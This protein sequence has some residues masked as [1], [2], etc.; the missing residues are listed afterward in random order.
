MIAIVTRMLRQSWYT[1]AIRCR[2]VRHNC[3]RTLSITPPNS[4][5]IVWPRRPRPERRARPGLLQGR[6]LSVPPGARCPA[7]MHVSGPYGLADVIRLRSSTPI[8][9]RGSIH[10]VMSFRKAVNS[11][12]GYLSES[13]QILSG[14]SANLHASAVFRCRSTFYYCRSLV[15]VVHMSVCA[16]A[17]IETLDFEDGKYD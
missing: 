2:S 9:W 11:R 7:F 5:G 15:L 13:Y 8:C 1:R 6:R 16:S 17:R 10:I 14:V 3:H 12:D 4:N